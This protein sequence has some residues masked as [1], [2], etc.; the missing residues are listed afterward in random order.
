MF[1]VNQSGPL[2]LHSDSSERF[3]EALTSVI[4]I[5]D[6]ALG[7]HSGPSW[8][9]TPAP[10]AAYPRGTTVLCHRVICSAQSCS[11]GI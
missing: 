8:P 10:S 5:K 2:C 9:T 6:I 3:L 7:T 11:S 4:N 1:M